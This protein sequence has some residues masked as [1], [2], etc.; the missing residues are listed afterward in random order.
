MFAKWGICSGVYSAP[1]EC[2]SGRRGLVRKLSPA[3]LN[4]G[5]PLTGTSVLAILWCYFMLKI[6][7]NKNVATA[8]GAFVFRH[9]YTCIYTHAHAH[10]NVHEYK[11]KG[12]SLLWGFCLTLLSGTFLHTIFEFSDELLWSKNQIKKN[13]KKNTTA[14]PNVGF[15][16]RTKS[17]GFIYRPCSAW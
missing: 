7:P 12:H 17:V 8:L 2:S 14:V 15:E 1:R 5:R 13:A 4:G 10:C 9:L 3:P 11:A 6:I 16:P